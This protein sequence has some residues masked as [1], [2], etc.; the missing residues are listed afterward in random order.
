MK[1]NLI[2]N[3]FIYYLLFTFRFCNGAINITEREL[4]FIYIDS[5]SYSTKCINKNL[6]G[7]EEKGFQY[8]GFSS[9]ANPHG[10]F[11]IGDQTSGSVYSCNRDGNSEHSLIDK[12]THCDERLSI[13]KIPI[14]VNGQRV[15]LTFSNDVYLRA[16]LFPIAKN[17]EMYFFKRIRFN[18]Q[19]IIDNLFSNTGCW[20]SDIS[21]EN[22]GL[23]SEDILNCPNNQI[24][25]YINQMQLLGCQETDTECIADALGS[26]KGFTNSTL[27]DASFPIEY[28]KNFKGYTKKICIRDAKSPLCNKKYR[29]GLTKDAALNCFTRECGDNKAT[30]NDLQNLLIKIVSSGFGT[31]VD[32]YVAPQVKTDLK[33]MKTLIVDEFNKQYNEFVRNVIVWKPALFPNW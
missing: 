15:K 22:F 11:G 6:E 31:F 1:V 5:V 20:I 23:R 3:F 19:N 26:R 9:Y 14:S 30:N 17:N 33:G 12:F 28:C 16:L 24:M 27:Y 10:A 8:I 7:I 21:I 4:P 25:F 13:I 32:K 18:G 2:I 29:T